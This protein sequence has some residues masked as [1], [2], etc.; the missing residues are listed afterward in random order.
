MQ[1]VGLVP[2]ITLRDVAA[3]ANLVDQ[4]ELAEMETVVTENYAAL[5]ARRSSVRASKEQLEL[6]GRLGLG[7]QPQSFP[8]WLVAHSSKADQRDSRLDKLMAELETA[9]DAELVQPFRQRAAAIAVESSAQRRALLTD[10]LVLELSERSRRRRADDICVERLREVHAGLRIL[11]APEARAIESQVA[12]ML[13][14]LKLETAQDLIVRA[15]AVIDSETAKLAA[16][17]R[18]RAVLEGLVKLGYEVREAMATAWARDGRLVVR[19]PGA[20]DYGIELGAPLDVSRL[21]VRLVGSHSPSMLRDAQRDRDM[22]TMWCSEFGQLQQLLAARGG[23]LVIERA[24]GVGVEPV[25]TVTFIDSER[26]APHKKQE[27]MAHR[28]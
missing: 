19:K 16:A 20:T 15:Q 5:V 17:A 10:S 14:S 24:V 23:E 27:Q 21:Q 8:E 11:G 9:E 12:S 1:A 28:S 4:R 2:P 25:K 3:R 26:D 7:E 18:R 22:E 13:Q 6:A